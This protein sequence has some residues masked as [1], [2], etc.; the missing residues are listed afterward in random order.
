MT[1]KE[2]IKEIQKREAEL[3]LELKKDEL[4]FGDNQHNYVNAS[5]SRWL[6][7][8]N[9]MQD[10]GIKPDIFYRSKETL[11]IINQLYNKDL[12]LEK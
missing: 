12:K 6:G 3:F 7:V 9:L 4:S 11:E 2:M 5:R 10:L 8:S 1:K